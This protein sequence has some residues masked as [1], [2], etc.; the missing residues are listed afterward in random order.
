MDYNM[1][2]IWNGC[3]FN[4]L[5]SNFWKKFW[6]K[7][8][9]CNLYVYC[10]FFIQRSFS[11]A[12]ANLMIFYRIINAQW[13]IIELVPIF[14]ANERLKIFFADSKT[15]TSDSIYLIMAINS[16]LGLPGSTFIS[17]CLWSLNSSCL[18]RRSSRFF[19]NLSISWTVWDFRLA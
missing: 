14:S 4:F 7:I 6:N 15:S 18:A 19:F 2:T 9:Q 5:A 8:E 16:Q 13:V 17:S 3:H 12:N 10:T 1:I 11:N